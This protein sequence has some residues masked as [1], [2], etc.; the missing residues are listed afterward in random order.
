MSARK[1][2]KALETHLHPGVW[3][4][5]LRRRNSE[6]LIRFLDWHGRKVRLDRETYA[7]I[8]AEEKLDPYAADLAAHDLYQL[9]LV[10]IRVAGDVGIVQLLKSDLDFWTGSQ[11]GGVR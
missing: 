4:N 11:K 6:R 3:F 8:Q 2:F 7:D 1:S 9:G 10:D 5:P